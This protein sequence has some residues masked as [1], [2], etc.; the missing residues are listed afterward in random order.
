MGQF[1]IFC[2]GIQFLTRLPCPTFPFKKEYFVDALQYFPVVGLLIGAI[3]VIIHYFFSQLFS[4]AVTSV[5]IIFVYVLITGGLHLDGLMDT[6]DGLFSHRSRERVLEIMKDSR[7]GA[8]GVTGAI[9]LLLLKYSIYLELGLTIF[10][11]AFLQILV[12]SRWSMVFLIHYLPYLRTEG[13]GKM[14][15]EQSTTR[16]FWVASAVT[17]L[18]LAVLDWRQGIALFA[19]FWLFTWCYGRAVT[20]ALG[21][22]TGDTYGACAELAEVF[23]LL[24]TLLLGRLV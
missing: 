4:T 14:Y 18:L 2:A 13:L 12:L 24:L 23:G 9:V 15:K 7:V 10:Y 5:L 3:L 22:L 19:L 11:V 6:I 16:Q 21:G 20:R 17:L 1:K 8:H